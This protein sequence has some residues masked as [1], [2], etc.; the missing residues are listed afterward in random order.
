MIRHLIL[1]TF[2]FFCIVGCDQ[3]DKQH[4]IDFYYWKTDVSFGKTEKDNFEQLNCK[5]LYIRFF[6]V[7][8]TDKGIE[9]LAKVKPFNSENLQAEFVPVVFI[10]NRTF[11]Q[12]SDNELNKLVNNISELIDLIAKKNALS[13]IKEIQIDCDWT[14]NTRNTYFHFLKKLKLQTKKKVT[15]TLRLHQISDKESA[16]IP[17]VEKGYLMCYATSSPKDFSEKNS[18]LDMKLLKKYTKNINDYQLDFDI[19]LPLY[20]WAVVENHLGNIKLI[21]GVTS[22]ELDSENNL[23]EIA[24]N[25]FEVKDDFF[26]H[27]IYLNKGF[28]IKLEAITP[29][30]LNEAKNYLNSKIKPNYNI[31]YYHLDAPFLE[32]FKINDLSS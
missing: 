23:T 8:K 30:L 11:L 4:N 25:L 10:T 16:G 13:E 32:Q 7:D 20:S 12:I 28:K 2:L 6:D 29:E 26:F 21:N 9:P 17:P 15:C 5:K 19:A 14:T 22:K 24:E 3:N 31:V 18:I 1:I 27:G